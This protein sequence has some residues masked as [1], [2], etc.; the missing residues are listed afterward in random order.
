MLL[1]SDTERAQ[2]LSAVRTIHTI[3]SSI[4]GIRGDVSDPIFDRE[5]WLPYGL[6]VS[7][8][9]GLIALAIVRRPHHEPGTAVT[10]EGPHSALAG[11]IEALPFAFTP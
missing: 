3:F 11:K 5:S 4:T 1:A 9:L 8:H 10:V 7:P 6:A 2:I